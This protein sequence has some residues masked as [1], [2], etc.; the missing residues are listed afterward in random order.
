MT[1]SSPPETE[2][3]EEIIMNN[4]IGGS[5]TLRG[6]GNMRKETSKKDRI[7]EIE[8]K[9][10]RKL[11]QSMIHN[12][13]YRE[14]LG[15]AEMKGGR[16]DM[17]DT[18][19][20][21]TNFRNDPSKTLL[22]SFDGHSGEK[23]AE[24]AS[25]S[26]GHVLAN[27]LEDKEREIIKRNK[28]RDREERTRD[29]DELGENDFIDVLN[30]TFYDMHNCIREHKF[31]DGTAALVVLVENDRKRLI[32][33]NA[34]DQRA[35]VAKGDIAVAIT[36]DHKPDEPGERLRIYDLGG[37][38]NE[39]KRVNGILALSRSL[40]DSDLQPYV[41]YVPEVNFVDLSSGDYR[42]LIIACDGLWDVV[43]NQKAIEIV[44]K[45]IDPIRAAAALRDYAHLLGST[46]NISV[47]VFRLD[48]DKRDNGIK[49]S[50]SESSSSS[51]VLVGQQ[52]VE[53]QENNLI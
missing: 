29:R 42:F 35:V 28:A 38:V 30:K 15:W 53:Q 18:I 19:A 47:I 7:A 20:V 25:I 11:R 1:N 8:K 40:G 37:F 9:K 17:Q 44:N 43:S 36:T 4:T 46:D 24:F 14:K 22:C 49:R 50:S 41:T 5:M 6:K 26:I 2:A 52:L 45:H 21:F 10:K 33:A 13:S 3:K 39:Q 48:F 51:F 31:D 34:G 16:P 23:S 27:N 32:V 12:E